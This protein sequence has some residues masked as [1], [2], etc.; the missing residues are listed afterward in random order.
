[1]LKAPPSTISRRHGF[2]IMPKSKFSGIYVYQYLTI[3]SSCIYEMLIFKRFQ[4]IETS[5][6]WLCPFSE[7]LLT[8]FQIYQS[9]KIF[10]YS[11][12]F[13]Q[14]FHVFHFCFFPL[15]FFVSF[16]LFVFFIL[17]LSVSNLFLFFFFSLCLSFFFDFLAFFAVS[18]F[19]FFVI[20]VICSVVLLCDY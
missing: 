8:G 9:F 3:S 12:F 2:Q 6:T 15:I 4:L 1:M 20:C 5:G 11:L 10:A 18:I 7:A 19:F 13:S 16:F 17:F 14:Q